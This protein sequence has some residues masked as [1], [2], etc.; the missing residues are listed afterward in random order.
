MFP[1]VLSVDHVNGASRSRGLLGHRDT[2]TVA[3]CLRLRQNT[4]PIFAVASLA[5]AA[6]ALTRFWQSETIACVGR[7]LSRVG[8]RGAYPMI[9]PTS[10]SL[11]DLS[12]PFPR[13]DPSDRV[14]PH[15][16][17]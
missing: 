13:P 4:K 6:A 10:V 3:A 17:G 5:C 8:P 11:F 14:A 2:A 16:L 7:F 12:A 9:I 15:E 1:P